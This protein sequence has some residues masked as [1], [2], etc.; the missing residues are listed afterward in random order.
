[1]QTTPTARRRSWLIIA[2]GCGTLFFMCSILT[3][4]A[5][6]LVPNTQ[7]QEAG[8]STAIVAAAP[9]TSP[10]EVEGVKPTLAVTCTSLPGRRPTFE[11]TV[12][13]TQAKASNSTTG[14]RPKASV[15][16]KPRS[17]TFSVTFP[18]SGA[19]LRTATITAKGTGTPGATVTRDIILESD[20]TTT[21]GATGRWNMLVNVDEYMEELKLRQEDLEGAAQT[22][23]GR[24]TGD[25]RVP[26]CDLG[27]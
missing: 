15:T 12:V 3:V 4:V 21:V 13:A 8:S 26:T 11:D 16:R 6:L 23:A 27:V 20:T 5:V 19:T 22:V 10:T 17:R 9:T 1:M 7:T 24:N 14:E 25:A 18:K 2:I